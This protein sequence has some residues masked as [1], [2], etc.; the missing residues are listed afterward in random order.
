MLAEAEE[1]AREAARWYEEQR[2]GLGQDFLDTLSAALQA[3][4]EQ[5]Q[6]YPLVETLRSRREVRQYFLRRFPYTVIY[7]VRP[8]EALVLAVAHARRR[9]NYWKRRGG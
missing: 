1:E 6:R 3:V 8:D 2:S 7:E 9:P 4:E 5:P